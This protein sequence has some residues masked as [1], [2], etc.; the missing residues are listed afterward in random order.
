MS[1]V[2]VGA[3]AGCQLWIVK[4]ERFGLWTRTP[5]ESVSSCGAEEIVTAFLELQNG[6]TRVRGEF[7]LVI[8]AQKRA[9]IKS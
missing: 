1:T 3:W 7:A 5:T 6:Y 4:D 8:A 9:R 2:A